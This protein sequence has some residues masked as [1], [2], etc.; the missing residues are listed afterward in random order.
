M[1][2]CSRPPRRTTPITFAASLLVA[3]SVHSLAQKPLT[4]DPDGQIVTGPEKAP[5][6]QGSPSADTAWSMLTEAAKD[7]R[8]VDGRIQA[9]AALGTM[10]LNPRAERFI[11]QAM[12][13]ADLDVRTAAILAAGQTGNRNLL[14]DLRSALDD[15]EP[16]VAFAAATTLCKLH[17]RSGEDILLAILQG[18]RS[19]APTLMNGARHTVIRDL[20]NPSTLARLGAMQGAS[21]L[22]GPFGFGITALE[23]MRKNGGDAARVEALN[24][25]AEQRST[26]IRSELIDA[27]SDRDP[28]VRAAAARALG[29]YH[30]QLA[31]QALVPALNDPK[32]PVRLTAAAAF[33][34]ATQ[35]EPHEHI[36][37]R[38]S[39]KPS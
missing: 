38:R 22:L 2:I 30:D 32:T 12:A 3:L 16:E 11:S 19:A 25:I 29:Q 9:I 10:G 14:F 33:I 21:F 17:D 4:G 27:L 39:A 23:Y 26:P 31:A 35:P 18:E 34:N 37:R 6:A 8:H 36:S 1:P 15:K 7:S 13:D 24:L 28:A 5:L 20:H